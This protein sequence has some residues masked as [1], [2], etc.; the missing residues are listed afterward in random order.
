[1]EKL[2]ENTFWVRQIFEVVPK[3]NILPELILKDQNQWGKKAELEV[4]QKLLEWVGKNE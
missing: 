2:I 1:M 3:N 4:N